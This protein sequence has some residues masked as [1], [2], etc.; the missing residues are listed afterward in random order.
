MFQPDTMVTL[1]R[2]HRSGMLLCVWPSSCLLTVGIV[3]FGAYLVM[4]S[5]KV[6]PSQR[7]YAGVATGPKIE[8]TTKGC[9]R[10]GGTVTLTTEQ[11]S[12]RW[13][14]VRTPVAGN[15]F[16]Q[17]IA[18]RTKACRAMHT[19]RVAKELPTSSRSTYTDACGRLHR[20][21]RHR[22]HAGGTDGAEGGSGLAAA[23]RWLL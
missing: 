15:L 8:G 1:G 16:H 22:M 10:A 13:V 6:Q 14:H 5:G 21:E 18:T 3:A 17:H 19:T 23:C 20:H 9:R 2:S 7:W 12:L 11:L 4:L